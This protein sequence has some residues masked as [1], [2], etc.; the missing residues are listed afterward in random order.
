MISRPVRVTPP[1]GLLTA[2]VCR[3]A[4]CPTVQSRLTC[5]AS[6]WRHRGHGQGSTEELGSRCRR[7]RR[8]RGAESAGRSLMHPQSES[9]YSRHGTRALRVG[10]AVSVPFAFVSF[11]FFTFAYVSILPIQSV[12]SSA[13]TGWRLCKYLFDRA[14]SILRLVTW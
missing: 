11:H 13:G 10:D 2:R 5:T 9:P 7:Y 1:S 3:C 14:G 12:F 4:P 8:S 6:E